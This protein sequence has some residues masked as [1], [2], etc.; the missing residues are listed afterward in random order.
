MYSNVFEHMATFRLYPSIE[1][2]LRV[3]RQKNFRSPLELRSDRRETSGK[4]I[5]DDLQLSIFWRRKILFANFCAIFFRFFV[6]FGRFW[7]DFWFF[8]VKIS[9]YIKFCFRCTLPEV[10]TT[11][12]WAFHRFRT[13][14]MSFFEHKECPSS[15][16]RI[17]FLRTQGLSFLEHEDCLSSNTRIVS[18][19]TQ[20]RVATSGRLGV[21]WKRGVL[22][23]ASIMFSHGGSELQTFG[24][25]KIPELDGYSKADPT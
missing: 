19:R 16:T 8:D 5:S 9:F 10:C 18:L 1:F 12:N 3:A 22:L 24:R 7:A 15:N 6:I 11:K 23:R 25:P 4:R 2:S 13:Q 17:V 14:G 20:G 21:Y